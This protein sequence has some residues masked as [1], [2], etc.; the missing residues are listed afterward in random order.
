MNRED[1]QDKPNILH[2]TG[3][4]YSLAVTSFHHDMSENAFAIYLASK[5]M[6]KTTKSYPKPALLNRFLYRLD[7]LDMDVSVIKWGDQLLLNFD[8]SLFYLQTDS[9]KREALFDY[10]LNLIEDCTYENGLFPEDIF[11]EEKRSLIK[12]IRIQNIDPVQKHFQLFLEKMFAQEPFRYSLLGKEEQISLCTN[13]EVSAKYK[14]FL[15][16]SGR[17]T[18]SIGAFSSQEKQI[19]HNI[20]RESPATLASRQKIFSRKPPSYFEEESDNQQTWLFLGYRHDIMPSHP[21]YPALTLY[22]QI[23]GKIPDALLIH[24]LREGLSLCYNVEMFMPAGKEAMFITAG[25]L[26]H[27]RSTFLDEIQYFMGSFPLIRK[28]N[29]LLTIAKKKVLNTITQWMDFPSYRLSFELESKLMDTEPT[30][31]DYCQNIEQVRWEDLQEASKHI[32]LD[33]VYTSRGKHS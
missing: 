32:W 33:T 22:Q 12:E 8:L 6:I 14:Q 2:Y 7:G 19:L 3:I 29:T 18:L 15:N 26:L 11:L 1:A 13:K 4:P 30:L 27:D 17:I 25:V 16:Q 21:L 28:K 31:Q 20:S 10:F 9:S 23:L 24:R 5:I